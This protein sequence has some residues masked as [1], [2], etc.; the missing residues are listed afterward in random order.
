[1][2][3][4]TFTCPAKVNL[5]LKVVRRRPDGY[6]DLVT[7]MQP[8]SLADELRLHLQ[9][10]GL[11][12][13]CSRPDLPR[14]AGNLAVRAVLAFQQ[15]TGQ[16]FGVHVELRKHIPV[17]AGLGGGSSNAAGVL[18]AL[19]EATGTPLTPARLAEVARTL[20]ADVPFFLLD[21]PA[22][23]RGIGDRLT[24]VVLPPMWLALANP[25]VAVSTASV[26][27]GLQPPFD[28]PDDSQ[29]AHMLREHPA[30]WLH[31]DLEGVTLR[32]HP[33]VA[34]CK[35]AL[36]RLGAQGVLMSGSGPTVFGLFADP[37][38]AAAAAAQLQAQTGYWT[39]AV[40]GL[41]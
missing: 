29:V 8:I 4:L 34:F 30:T 11:T 13:E 14:D 2:A 3:V 35:E 28:P 40:R 21:G 31:N 41:P 27:A 18:R 25:G 39:A 23:A 16:H 9:A 6:H 15:A 10:E 32:R 26:Y 22:L 36:Q 1:M 20:G 37:S 24:P 38:S 12:C 7:I 19:N 33:E 5:Y 17:A